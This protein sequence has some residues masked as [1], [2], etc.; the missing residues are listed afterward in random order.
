M[1][2]NFDTKI[3]WQDILIDPE[4]GAVNFM[5]IYDTAVFAGG[6]KAGVWW[7]WD[8]DNS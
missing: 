3:R 4:M 5:F 6:S 8:W 1:M 2:D 7:Q